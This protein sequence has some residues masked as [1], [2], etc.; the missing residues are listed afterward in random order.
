MDLAT[1]I[2]PYVTRGLLEA[3]VAQ[4]WENRGKEGIAFKGDGSW[5]AEIKELMLERLPVGTVAI[6]SLTFTRVT[7][8]LEL[9]RRGLRRDRFQ[10][11]WPR[12]DHHRPGSPPASAARAIERVR[13]DG[14]GA[15]RCGM[16]SEGGEFADSS[17]SPGTPLTRQT[18]GICRKSQANPVRYGRPMPI[19]SALTP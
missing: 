12:W 17:A 1:V 10:G 5:K 7:A 15:G 8:H 2:K 14:N 4:R 18:W 13:T 19:R 9:S 11:R 16:G 3:D 6:P